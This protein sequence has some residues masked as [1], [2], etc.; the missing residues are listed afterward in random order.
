[1]AAS[2]KTP[3]FASTCVTSRGPDFSRRPPVRRSFRLARK[4]DNSDELTKY[5]INTTPQLQP[6]ATASA[7]AAT[8][9]TAPLGLNARRRYA[10]AAIA[11]ASST[12][13]SQVGT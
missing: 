8:A 12:P 5:A 4:R 10:T 9:A 11:L 1:M 13:N 6:A 7:P 2:V 3:P